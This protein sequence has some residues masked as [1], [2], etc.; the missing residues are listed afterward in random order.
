MAGYSRH[1]S[2]TVHPGE[3]DLPWLPLR[4]GLNHGNWC[5]RGETWRTRGAAMPDAYDTPVDVD[6][7]AQRVEARLARL[8]AR[9]EQLEAAVERRSGG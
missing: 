3:V 6:E 5:G 4:R 2:R 9:M 1:T 7:A 8:D